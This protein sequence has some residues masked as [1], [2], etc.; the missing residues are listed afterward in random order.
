MV[1]PE[2]RH[3]FKVPFAG[4]FVGLNVIG[5][6]FNI[7]RLPFA[8]LKEKRA[9]GSFYGAG[10]TVGYHKILTPHWGFEVNTSL[11]YLHMDYSRYRCGHCGYK[12]MTFSKNYIT[13]TRF[14]FSIVYMIK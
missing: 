6:G 11:D 1:Q 2:L 8:Q 5:G 3:W 9:Q 12:E 14:S 4:P 10:I 13:P 7:A